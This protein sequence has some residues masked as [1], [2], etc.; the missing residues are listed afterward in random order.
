M[1]R[2]DADALTWKATHEYDF[3]KH[4]TINQDRTTC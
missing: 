4:I 2:V 3:L 1:N